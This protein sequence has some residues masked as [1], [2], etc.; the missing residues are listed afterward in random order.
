MD[1]AEHRQA[2]DRRRVVNPAT[3][4]T[5]VQAMPDQRGT[6]EHQQHRPQ[7][8][9]RHRDDPGRLEQE[10]APCAYE[11]QRGEQ[12][13]AAARLPEFQPADRDQPERPVAQVVTGVD[14]TQVVQREQDSDEDDQQPYQ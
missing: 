3:L 10:P 11:H 8:P 4:A 13:A 5:A 7:I 1:R 14:H 12:V 9:Q 2:A 6:K